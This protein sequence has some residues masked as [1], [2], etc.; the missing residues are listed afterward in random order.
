MKGKKVYLEIIRILSIFLVI[1]GHTGADAIGRYQTAGNLFSYGLSLV[2]YC[3][4]QS[5]IP[6]FFFISG[7]VLLHKEESLQTVLLHRAARVL[8]IILLF[9]F[10][11]YLYFYYLNP[12]IGFSIPAFFKLVYNSTVITQ[13]WYLY[14]YF[15]L[16][17]IL[18]FVR[19]L[20]RSMENIHFWYLFGL[21]F[22]LEGILPIVE[23]LW[24][25][26]RIVLSVPLFEN[27]LFY[28][29]L[30]Y[31]LA[32]RS[33]KLFYQGKVL[34]LTNV[35]GFFALLTNTVVAYM[36]HRQRG[37]VE[38]L[39]GMTIMLALVIFIDIRALCHYASN[40]PR[41]VFHGS[42]L[43]LLCK[44]VCF[45]GSGVFGVYLLEP[46]LR[47]SFRFIYVAT[48]PYISWLPAVILWICSAILFGAVLFWFLKKLPVLRKIL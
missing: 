14:T 20:A 37:D 34:L 10:V 39:E 21:F 11:E 8:I 17:L 13:Y 24:G 31:Y 25:N 3:I 47:D 45:I 44:A 42:L 9:G 33:G 19:M 38:S 28:P 12:E 1:Y 32:Q 5:S 2:L 18:P 7:A 41:P 16:M 23:Y 27:S 15:T 29:L 22:L 26:S 36:A 43:K 48:E 6:L 40:S 46:P 35:M 30:G 4:V